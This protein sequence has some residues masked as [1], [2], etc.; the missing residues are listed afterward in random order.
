MKN[1]LLSFSVRS[2]G[3]QIDLVFAFGLSFMRPAGE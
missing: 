1:D 2:S 3:F